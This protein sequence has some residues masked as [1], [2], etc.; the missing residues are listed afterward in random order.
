LQ[1]RR[2]SPGNLVGKNPF[3]SLGSYRVRGSDFQSPRQR[4]PD[5]LDPEPP[6]RVELT[7]KVCAG[8][9]VPLSPLTRPP[10]AG[11]RSVPG[12]PGDNL[13]AARCFGSQ[14]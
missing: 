8:R 7:Q 1:R 6:G 5:V 2:R 13:L 10:V 4:T 11:A 14:Q 9:R 12:G 3:A